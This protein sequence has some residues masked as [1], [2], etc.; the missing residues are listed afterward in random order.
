MTVGAAVVTEAA[1]SSG[2]NLPVTANAAVV[3]GQAQLT[4]MRTF[5]SRMAAGWKDVRNAYFE[6]LLL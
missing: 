1:P 6:G 3:V 2:A 5:T 4:T